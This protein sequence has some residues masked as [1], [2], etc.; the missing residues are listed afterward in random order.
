M[1]AQK[2]KS[3]KKWIKPRHKV[4]V[5]MLRFLL[6]P[7]ICG[8]YGLKAERFQ[9]ENGRQYLVLANHQT[10]FDQFFPSLVFKQHLYYVASEDIFSMGWLSKVIQWL[11]APIPIKKQVTDI[12]A[13]MNCMRV[14][15]EGGSI[16]MFPEGNRTFSGATGFMNPA[17]GGLAKKLGMP[18]AF[19]KIEG[20]YGVQPRWSDVRRRGKMRAYVSSVLEPEEYKAWTSEQLYRH[21]CKE[22][23]QNE[24]VADASF[25]HKKSAE[26]IERVLYVC[27]QCGIT[28]FES[29]GDTFRCTSCGKS[30]RYLPTKEISGEFPFRFMLDWYT[31]QENYINSLDT[32]SMVEAPIIRDRCA[33]YQVALYSKKHL[34]ADNVELALYGDRIELTGGFREVFPFESVENIT[35]LGKNKLD[36]YYGDMVYQIQSDKRFNALKYLNL[37][38]RYKNLTSEVQNGSFLGL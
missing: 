24:A 16:A 15:K 27:P 17:I 28:H 36:I 12:K 32:L 5:P 2:K 20:G 34:L 29:D 38:H 25:R 21:I 35:I 30:A 14:A 6:K 23:Y 8:L 19:L 22:L 7:F 26:Y 33:L 1:I 37:Y 13:V 10:G 3:V 11:V 18:I 9:E 31:Y 4:L